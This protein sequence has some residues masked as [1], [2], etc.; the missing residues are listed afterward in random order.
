M[1]GDEALGE[2]IL[3]SAEFHLDRVVDGLSR[4]T[5]LTFL[6]PDDFLVIEE[7]TGKVKRV[8]DGEISQPILDL[9]VSTDDSR[10]LIGIDSNQN[11]SKTFVFLYYTESS[12]SRDGE[13]DPLGNRLYRY[14]LADF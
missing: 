5:G 7:D 1:Q 13:H 8:I 11:G 10:G 4:P 3:K 12:S 9:N 6:G 2:P 14:E